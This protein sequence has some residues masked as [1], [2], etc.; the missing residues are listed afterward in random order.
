MSQAASEE[1]SSAGVSDVML[2][3]TREM[4]AQAGETSIVALTPCG[5]VCVCDKCAGQVKE[6]PWCKVKVLGFLRIFLT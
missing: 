1:M 2:Q 4:G 5:H 6:C 3:A